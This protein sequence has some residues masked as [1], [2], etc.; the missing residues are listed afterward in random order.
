[1]EIVIIGLIGLFVMFGLVAVFDGP[2]PNFNSNLVGL[3]RGL[4]IGSA[5]IAWW[6]FGPTWVK[7]LLAA[8]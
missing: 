7:A 1:M 6:L 8:I 2:N 4:V 3:M 5:L